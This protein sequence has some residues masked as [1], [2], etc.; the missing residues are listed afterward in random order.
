MLDAKQKRYS[1][2][3]FLASLLNSGFEL[4][5]VA[6]ILPFIE[7]VEDPHK[8]MN[9]EL[10]KRFSDFFSIYDARTLLLI[11]C[12]SIIV[13]YLLKSSYM[14]FFVWLK[15]DFT[16]KFAKKM[17]TKTLR[18]FL[19]HPYTYFLDINS[20][21]ILDG[22]GADIDGVSLVISCIFDIMSSVI[23][24]FILALYLLMTD[25][26]TAAALIIVMLLLIVLIIMIIKPIMK[27][28]G[29]ED[30]KITIEKNTALFQISMGIKEIFVAQKQEFFLEK[31]DKAYEKTRLAHRKYEF[32]SGI[33]A[34]IIEGVCAS[35]II[36]I[37]GVRICESNN[38]SSD[39][40]P[41]LAVFA[42][43]AFKMF[44]AVSLLINRINTMV[45]ARPRVH[46][47]YVN[48]KEVQEYSELMEERPQVVDR[49]IDSKNIKFERIVE[50][51]NLF[52]K[53]PKQKECVLE[54]ISLKINKGD[55]IAFIGESG[56]G[57]TTLVDIIL[58]LFYPNE[59]SI[60]M[61]GID[62]FSIPKTWAKVIC[63]VPQSVYL[64]DD[65]IRNNVVFGV[66]DELI[67]DERVWECLKEAQ[68]Y[69][70]VKRLP[71]G[72]DTRVGERGVKFSGGQR[73]RIAIA[74]AL[75]P[76][77]D[78]LVLDEATAAL[79]YETERAIME[80]IDTLKG[81]IT[82]IIIAHRLNTVKNCDY[83]YEV[84]DKSLLNRRK[85]DVFE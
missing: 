29:N 40:L 82:L 80:S 8:L 62:I 73:Q 83:I 51:E 3:V 20:S 30:V 45:Y 50:I 52:W 74:R 54:N 12:A 70:F 39:F 42:M 21:K 14:I 44:P 22:C 49:D 41:K 2:V 59:G 76:N 27:R 13:V 1:I 6:I 57:K 35:G 48:Y 34:R 65:N 61:D 47:V 79:D 84:K 24:I 17:A 67:S 25:L 60:K 36:L 26:F 77:P 78:I 9:K 71:E 37:L 33:P 63:Y 58:G 28:V 72:L 38:I 75:Y 32:I 69:D 18:S 23:T 81:K 4:I 55:S 43:A 56:A 68:L 85:E 53:Y 64:I 66:E 11:I 19:S 31:Y 46:N 16:T 10:I 15:S 5:G 7:M